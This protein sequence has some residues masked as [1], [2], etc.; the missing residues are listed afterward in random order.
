MSLDISII[1]VNWNTRDL[2]ADCLNSIARTAAGMAHE[3]IVVDNASSDGSREMVREHFPHVRL[4]VNAGNVGFAKANNQAI[5]ASAGRYVLLLNSDTVVLP[6]ALPAL[7]RFMDAHPQV[8]IVGAKLLNRDGT[9]QPSWARFPT[10][11][12]EL[13]GRNSRA[14]ERYLTREGALAFAVDWVGGACFM[15]CRAVVEEVGL[16]DEGYFMYSEEMDWCFRVRQKSWLVC[17][18]PEA[19]VVHLGRQSSRQA[20]LRMKAELYQSKLTFFHKHYGRDRARLL[21]QLLQLRFLFNAAV[22]RM[23]SLLTLNRSTASNTFS[24][25]AWALRESL[26]QHLTR[27]EAEARG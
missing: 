3:I 11:W 9:L 7:V 21:G 1:I 12:S 14:R 26:R 8:G 5:Q 17:Y 19:Q 10:V 23:F 2:L 22:G 13:L 18:Y 4:L 15:I 25:N 24:E 20:S 27:L 16:L 6:G